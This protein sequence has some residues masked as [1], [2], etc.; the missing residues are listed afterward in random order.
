MQE[1]GQNEQ[2]TQPPAGW[3]F[4]P[5]APPQ[6]AAP[7]PVNQAESLVQDSYTADN[8]SAPLTNQSPDTII[9]WTA[10]EYVGNAKA[11][12][13][14][15][16][17]A[18][19]TVSVTVIVYLLTGDLISVIVIAILGIIIGVFAARQP[20]VL[21]YGLDRSGIHIGLRFFPYQSFKTFTVVHEGAFNHISL[22]PLKRFIPPIAIHYSPADEDKITNTLAD[23]LPYEEHKRDMIE[24]FSHKVRF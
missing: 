15:A 16:M 13:W 14:F 5:G 9:A 20:Q 12:S 3:V 19:A 6:P 7:Q 8:T 23:Y 4:T 11:M 18:A 1:K 22:L 24:S 10:S 21:Q 2:H 17:L